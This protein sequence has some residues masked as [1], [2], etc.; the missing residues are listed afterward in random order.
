MSSPHARAIRTGSHPVLLGLAEKPWP[1]SD[2]IT[3]WKAS[4]AL[5]PW[6]VGLVSGSMILS[7]SMIEPG[8]PCVTIIGSASSCW[9]RTWMKWR[10]SPSISVM[11]FGR[12]FSLDSH[13]LQS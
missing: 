8:H 10:S 4:D 2:G 6:E 9:E 3:R 5:A 7:C 1:G 13:L 11:K 12:A